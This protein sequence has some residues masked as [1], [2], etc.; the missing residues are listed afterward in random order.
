MVTKRLNVEIVIVFLLRETVA[1]VLNKI[2]TAGN[3]TAIDENIEAAP[4]YGQ[5]GLLLEDEELVSVYITCIKILT[6]TV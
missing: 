5:P 6:T 3:S 4:E 2:S 1:S